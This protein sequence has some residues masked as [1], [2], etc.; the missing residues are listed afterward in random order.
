MKQN[1]DPIV[2]EVRA[3][4]HRIAAFYGNNLRRIAEAAANGFRDF[5]DTLAIPKSSGRTDVDTISHFRASV[6]TI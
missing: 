2:A 4:R 5:C 3:A 1:E 6:S